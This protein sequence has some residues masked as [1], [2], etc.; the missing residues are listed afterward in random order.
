MKT[1]S[2]KIYPSDITRGQFEHIREIL[3]SAR[4]RTKPRTVDLYDVFNAVLYVL[5]T[6]C[7]WRAMP[8]EYPK[9]KT[10]HAY[11]TLWAKESK[12]EKSLLSW[13]L[14]KIGTRRSKQPGAVLYDY[15]FN[16]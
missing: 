12:G 5:K 14:K 4:K 15:L 7:Q 6:G 8:S 16:S 1:K 13:C 11:F 9:W 3:E 2:R 10:V